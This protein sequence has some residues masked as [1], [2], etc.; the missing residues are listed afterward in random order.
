MQLERITTHVPMHR[1]KPIPAPMA[2]MPNS[3]HERIQTPVSKPDLTPRFWR[4]DVTVNRVVQERKHPSTASNSIGRAV[5]ARDGSQ[6]GRLMAFASLSTSWDDERL[7][8]PTTWTVD[9]GIA[10]YDDNSQSTP[11]LHARPHS[12]SMEM[13]ISS[14]S[15]AHP[16]HPRLHPR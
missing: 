4:S 3:S 16:K 9:L 5:E 15:K 8:H 12:E 6:R 2:R 14:T 11:S 13:A 1:K 10:P 7:C